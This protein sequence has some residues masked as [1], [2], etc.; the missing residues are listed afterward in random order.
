M[1][2]TDKTLLQPWTRPIQAGRIIFRKRSAVHFTAMS[3]I[4]SPLAVLANFASRANCSSSAA[5]FAL[6]RAGPFACLLRCGC[7][8][9]P[10]SAPPHHTPA[11]PAGGTEVKEAS[12]AH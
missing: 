11:A 4:A 3:I 6:R 8:G 12:A 1:L 7:R 9:C 5:D 10:V 2:F